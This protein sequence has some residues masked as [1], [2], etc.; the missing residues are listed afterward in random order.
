MNPQTDSQWW[1]KWAPS[2]IFVNRV[3]KVHDFMNGVP[4]YRNGNFV[5]RGSFYDSVFDVYSMVG[6]IPA[7]AYTAVAYANEIPAAATIYNAR[8]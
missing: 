4:G 7:A 1:D 2:K 3:S 8:R 5:T 6:M